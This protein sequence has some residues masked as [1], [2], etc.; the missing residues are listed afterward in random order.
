[1]DIVY[2]LGNG[3]KV[4]DLEIK[5][6]LRSLERHMV[7]KGKVFIIGQCPL[8]LK[9][10]IY[11]PYLETEI[12]PERNILQKINLACF[13]DR[14]SDDFLLMNDDFFALEDFSGADLPFYCHIKGVGN[15][16][17][18]LNFAVHMPYRINK[19]MWL[20]CP[21]PEK[22]PN[23]FSLRSF[24][25]N[26]YK[27]PA[28]FHPDPILRIGLTKETFEEQTKQWDFFSSTSTIFL[29]A[30]FLS[31]LDKKYSSPSTYEILS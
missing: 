29:N 30:E 9:N 1:M 22:A 21:F 27:A 24:Y 16:L 6:S 19:K 12:L 8:F 25:L 3:S 20:S 4:Y 23:G 7:D 26:Y 28:V 18:P 15:I 17:I 13:D 2:V 5:Y 31:W 11:I 10:V 14:I